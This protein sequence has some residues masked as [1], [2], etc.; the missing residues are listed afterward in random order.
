MPMR[1]QVIIP[2]LNE[3]A[4]IGRVIA[5]LPSGLVDRVIVVDN[6]STD[7]TAEVALAA[8]VTVVAE[9]ARGYGAACLRGI[10]SLGSCDVVVFID[11]DYSDYPDELPLLL[12]PI[13]AGAADLVI[14]S[15]TLGKSSRKALLPQ[16]RFGNWLSSRLLGWAFGGVATDLG[17]FR[18]IRA[19]VLT[20]LEMDDRDFGWTVQMQARAM[21]QGMRVVEVP[22]SYRTR[23]GYSKISGT[24]QGSVRAGHKILLTIWR[25]YRSAAKARKLAGGAR[26]GES[27]EGSE[28]G[29]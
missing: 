5:E 14:G 6:G 16:A 17:P 29:Q 25:E 7:R 12:A 24:I 22:V 15:R 20:R 13:E 27:L 11:A 9:P 10:E 3:E 26:P 8:G 19:E 28:R 1:V 23:I 21:A 2:A 4:S 18:A